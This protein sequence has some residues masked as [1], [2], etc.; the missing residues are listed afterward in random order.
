MRRG[1]FGFG[2]AT[3]SYATR[4]C[5]A[6]RRQAWRACTSRGVLS[7]LPTRHRSPLA[8]EE[9]IR[10]QHQQQRRQRPW[11]EH[12]TH[13]LSAPRRPATSDASGHPLLG[14]PSAGR[15]LARPLHPTGREPTELREGEAHGRL[16]RRQEDFHVTVGR[17]PSRK[18]FCT[19]RSIGGKMYR[20]PRCVSVEMRAV[21]VS[22]PVR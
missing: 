6:E 14:Q 16:R 17:L 20:A 10:R 13:D 11:S 15:G 5:A 12:G 7:D 8:Y 18:R 4:P 9:G 19:G 1:V 2:L 22:L 21:G 3:L